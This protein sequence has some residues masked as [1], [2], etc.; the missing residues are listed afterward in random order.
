[1]DISQLQY[2]IVA[3]RE[4][5][6][7]KASEMLNLSQSALSRSIT[8]LERELGLSLFDREKRSIRL[9]KY[10]R[11]FYKE[12]QRIVKQLENMKS[13]L[14]K[15]RENE[16][17]EQLSIT[18]IHSLGLNYIPSLLRNFQKIGV[19]CSIELHESR[20]DEASNSLLNEKTDFVF[21]TE[22]DLFT[23]LNYI[24]LFT[25]KIV[26]ICSAEHRFSSM[27]IVSL[28]EISKED[29]IHYNLHTS[30][31][32]LIDKAFME[33]NLDINISYEGI[34][35]NSII[36]LVSANMGIALVPESAVQ[37]FSNVNV[38]P[39]NKL[40]LERTIYFMHHRNKTFNETE[41]A[42]KNFTMAYHKQFLNTY[43]VKDSNMI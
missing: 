33:Y 31:R 15:L 40:H 3:A 24:P 37:N 12:A 14:S 41:S 43:H 4:E 25:E 5:H 16:R 26:L 29:F 11:E 20:A 10:G 1:M 22:Y 27:D 28:E 32:R 36:G 38:V 6:M 23:D 42:F 30:L 8:A 34:E 13:N 39:T 17:I 18:F 21:G 35:I 9:N 19:P 7:T 2:F